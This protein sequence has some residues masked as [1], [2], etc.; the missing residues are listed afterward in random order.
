VLGNDVL[1]LDNIRLGK[2]RR[3]QG[4]QERTT[5]VPRDKAGS[6]LTRRLVMLRMFLFGA[7]AGEF[8]VRTD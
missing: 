7:S 6:E 2:A 3:Q 4:M 8:E 5:P 1:D